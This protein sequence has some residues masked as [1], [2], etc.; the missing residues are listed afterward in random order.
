[1]AARFPVIVSGA[2]SIVWEVGCDVVTAGDPA[3]LAL[4]MN[5]LLNDYRRRQN[6]GALELWAVKT[7][8]SWKAIGKQMLDG[9]ADIWLAGTRLR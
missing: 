5:R 3:N 4:A 6:M 2:A 1:M 8:Y 9:Y 7:K